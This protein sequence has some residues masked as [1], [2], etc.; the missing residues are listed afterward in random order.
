M[1]KSASRTFLHTQSD[2][3]LTTLASAGNEAAFAVIVERHRRVLTGAC[4]RVLPPARVEDAVQ[5]TFLAA[6]SAMRRGDDIRDL[7]PWLLR[8]ARNTALNALRVRG[9]DYEA[10][11]ESVEVGEAP[12]AELE[13][14]EV[15]RST[16]AGLAALPETQR[17][18]LLD[19]AVR[20][21]PH[22]QIA[23]ELGVSEG[24]VRQLVLRARASLRAAVT[25]VVPLPVV[26]WLAEAGQNGEPSAARIVELASGAAPVGA[27]AVA[28]LAKTSTVVVVAGGVAVTPA[29]VDRSDRH[30]APTTSVTERAEA[31]EAPARPLHRHLSSA[32]RPPVTPLDRGEDD[33]D[34]ERGARGDREDEDDHDE[35]DRRTRRAIQR[36]EHEDEDQKDPSREGRSGDADE[37]GD[38]GDEP[39]HH[40]PP[41]EVEGSGESD[42]APAVGPTATDTP[43]IQP[44]SPP[45]VVI[46]P[47][48][49][50]ADVGQD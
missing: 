16:L 4:R 9:Y 46:G 7:R 32:P 15:I 33:R 18:A 41:A 34:I 45:T 36:H 5:Q 20:G 49:D 29:L 13:R 44:A 2:A 17:E 31:T 22:A 10:L 21:I 43:E 48:P 25:A 42:R 6:W 35:R 37:A 3:R 28:L 40:Q 27:G 23:R 19:S 8:V 38:P 1:L 47:S 14:R 12:P 50:P 11:R 39:R 24:A 30:R 26:K